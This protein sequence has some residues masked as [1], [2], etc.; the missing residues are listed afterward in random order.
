M[1]LETHKH[2]RK[3]DPTDSIEEKVKNRHPSV[4]VPNLLWYDLC[5]IELH[6]ATCLFN[7]LRYLDEGLI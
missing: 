6:S 1:I 2:L 3:S 4:I 7:R 5:A